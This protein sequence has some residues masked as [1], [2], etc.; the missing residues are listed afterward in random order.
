MNGFAEAEIIARQDWAPGL[1][2]LTVAA[3]TE[4]FVAGQFLNLG[5]E[6]GGEV[7]KRPY[8]IA[9]APGQPLQF[10]LKEVRGGGFTPE[11]F[12]LGVGAPLLVERKPQGFFTLAYV[13]PCSEMWFVATGTGLGP[14]IAMLRSGE[15][16]QRFERVVLVHGVRAP[17]EL[18]YTEELAQWAARYPGR[19]THVSLVSGPVAGAALAGRVTSALVAGTLEASA[20]VRLD[21]ERSHVMLC[22]NPQMIAEFTQLL[23]DRGLRKHR[24][25]TPG[26][27]TSE[28]YW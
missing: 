19:F 9:A 1:M 25:R 11:I 28:K 5:L 6:R 22:G 4:P 26:H 12:R 17:A 16:F 14:F 24:V 15:P 3:L 7:V 8:S 10:Y 2:T 21:P 27:V 18:S 20:G 13:P 23:G